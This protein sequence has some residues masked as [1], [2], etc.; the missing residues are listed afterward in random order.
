MSQ[1][2]C[3]RRRG[4][5]EKSKD[6]KILFVLLCLPEVFLLLHEQTGAGSGSPVRRVQDDG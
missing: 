5:D 2:R 1:E 3:H 4:K 6:A